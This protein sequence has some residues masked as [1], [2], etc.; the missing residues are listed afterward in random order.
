MTPTVYPSVDAALEDLT[1]ELP[2]LEQFK[3]TMETSGDSK[4][5][6]DQYASICKLVEM[7]KDR[8][9]FRERLEA[10]KQPDGSVQFSLTPE[11][12]SRFRQV[13]KTGL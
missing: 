8:N 6:P 10:L 1:K 3:D 13:E 12:W 7:L 11:A 9:S 5:K 4:R 2:L